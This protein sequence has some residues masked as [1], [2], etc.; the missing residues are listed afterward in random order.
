MSYIGID[1]GTSSG[2][3][4]IFSN[5][6]LLIN[7]FEKT[8]K[9]FRKSN[10]Y[11]EQN[12]NDWFETIKLCLEN[13][14]SFTKEEVIISICSQ[15]NTHVFVDKSGQPL[16][17]AITWQDTR[18]LEEANKIDSL[19]PTEKKIEWFGTPIPIDSSNVLSRMLWV[20]NNH[21]EIWEKTSYVLLPKDFCIFHLTGRLVTDPISNIGIVGKNNR[22]IPELIS[23][24]DGAADK[25]VPIESMRTIVGEV[26][27]TLPFKNSPVLC[28][29]MDA[30]AGLIG[31]GVYNKNT[32][33]Y[34]SGTSEIL[35]VHSPEIIPTEG[36]VV[37]PKAEKIQ[38]HAGPTQN[39]GD[40][41]KWFSEVFN[42][43]FSEISSLISSEDRSINT[44]LF[45]PQL[46]GERA[47]IWDSNLRASF[48]GV[49]RSTGKADFAR[50]VFEGVGFAAF[51]IQQVLEISS[52]VKSE[53][54]YCSGNGFIS[55]EW[56]QIRANIFGK[57]LL[58]S[59]FLE[60][61]ILG[62]VFLAIGSKNNETMDLSKLN[63]LLKIKKT[64]EPD[65]NKHEFYMTLFEEYKRAVIS[66]GKTNNKIV[67]MN[68][69][70]K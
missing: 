49:T 37:F 68:S 19:I 8:Y 45:L 26:K 58:V 1:I 6:G 69:N 34:I 67:L 62:S 13:F 47:P 23:L 32:T 56:S 51:W 50:A 44:P 5:S 16:L 64:F 25:L 27:T 21:P 11:V 38:L 39:G 40:A 30:W 60:P 46:E 12:P 42:I 61:G 43:S 41:Q 17:P 7:K 10:K 15:V 57:P 3:G 2:K 33:S 65:L 14:N 24:V 59:S 63:K 36:A 54:I 48:L 66:V 9:T 4:A 52:N 18:C 55:N 53:K 22:Y 35:G 28:G 20:S 31:T 70:Y 29:T